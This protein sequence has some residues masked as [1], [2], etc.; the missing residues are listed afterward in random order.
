MNGNYLTP[1]LLTTG[2]SFANHWYNTNSVDIKILVAGGI[3]TGILG[4]F[5][6]I[7]GFSDV[8]AGIAW[9]AFAAMMI[10]P[11]QKPSPVQNLLKITG[12]K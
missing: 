5:S 11:I 4:I 2:V 7:P 6:N 9:T 12:S 10:A 3:A 1:M 8:A